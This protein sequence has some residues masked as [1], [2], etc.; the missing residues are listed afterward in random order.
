M[1]AIK[2]AV[3]LSAACSMLVLTLASCSGGG[4][5]STPTLSRLDKAKVAYNNALLA[6]T[7]AE[8]TLADARSTLNT[9]TSELVT[10]RSNQA[11]RTAAIAQAEQAK[12]DGEKEY[13][14]K[15]QETLAAQNALEKVKKEQEEP[16]K[17]QNN[18]LGF[19]IWNAEDSGSD[20][21]YIKKLFLDSN[22]YNESK[23]DLSSRYDAT[24]LQNFKASIP[25][26]DKCN[27]MRQRENKAEGTTLKDLLIT[28]YAMASA[29]LH[30]NYS[31][32][33]LGH[34]GNT[35]NC[36]FGFGENLAWGNR[37]GEDGPFEAWYTDEKINYR[38]NPVW[39]GNTGHY[40]NIVSA[41]GY[42]YRETGFAINTD[43]NGYFSM[44]YAQEFGYANRPGKLY[45]TDQYRARIAAYENYL[46]SLDTVLNN[47]QQ[48]VTTASNAEKAAKDQLTVLE[49]NIQNARKADEDALKRIEALPDIIAADNAAIQAA[50]QNL[51]AQK[52]AVADALAELNS[53]QAEQDSTAKAALETLLT[54]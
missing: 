51:E 39:T 12:A 10:L 18:S 48:T 25:W 9:H 54:A 31:S 27:E 13:Q 19:F 47:A 43:P 37:A 33:T 30:A 1:K 28:D 32:R 3:A 16:R 46:K 15:Q 23:P 44:T 20:I 49:R 14:K 34:H 41:Y 26:I 6:Q 52:K 17:Y 29:Q 11:E 40:L 7:Q 53:A 42:N 4:S 8:Q 5:G 45:T 38:N 2:K 50:E 24:S 22:S 36:K 35:G 21:E